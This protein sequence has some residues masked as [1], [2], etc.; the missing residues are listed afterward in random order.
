MS[1]PQPLGLRDPEFPLLLG[2]TWYLTELSLRIPWIQSSSGY[3][4]QRNSH[5]GSEK[6]MCKDVHWGVI[7]SDR[8]LKATWDPLSQ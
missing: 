6:G 2:A 8:E 5:T 1:C 4:S 7:C 3:I